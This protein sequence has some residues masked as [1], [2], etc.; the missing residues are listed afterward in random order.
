VRDALAHWA[1]GEFRTVNARIELILRRALTDAGW[2]PKQ[3]GPL[4]RRGRPPTGTRDQT[5]ERDQM[6]SPDEG[7]LEMVR[8]MAPASA[9]TPSKAPE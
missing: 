4:P 6:P 2:M 5:A 3:T 8:S 7:K 9:N 1:V